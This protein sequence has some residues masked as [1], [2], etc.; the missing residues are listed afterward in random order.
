MP[1]EVAGTVVGAGRRQEGG[2]YF[3][4]PSGVLDPNMGTEDWLTP[5]LRKYGPQWGCIEEGVLA[6]S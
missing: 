4:F 2:G 5:H 1:I 3:L 6:G